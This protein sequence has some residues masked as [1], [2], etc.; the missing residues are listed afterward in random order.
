[1]SKQ[2]KTLEQWDVDLWTWFDAVVQVDGRMMGGIPRNKNLLEPW[3][4]AKM[5]KLKKLPEDAVDEHE[6]KDEEVKGLVLQTKEELADQLIEDEMESQWVGF[7]KVDGQLVFEARCV[8][9][10]F[11]EAANV[12]R[13]KAKIAAFKSKV[14]ERVFIMPKY[15]P[16]DRQEPDGWEERPIHVDTPQ[17]PRSALK[18]SDYVE[19]V[20]LEFKVKV[21]DEPLK[22]KNKNLVNP[23]AYL[24]LLLNYMCDN[25]FGGDRSQGYG[26]LRLANFK[27]SSGPRKAV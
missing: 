2:I 3:T 13:E 17:G 11:K 19:N 4:R 25:G 10:A 27:A 16:L 6:R 20:V 9:A 24:G 23:A 22:D 7:K 5:E 26:K 15:I 14:A 1:M 18:R 21:L 12:L 8:K